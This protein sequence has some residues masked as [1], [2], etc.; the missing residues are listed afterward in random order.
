[1]VPLSYLNTRL[2]GFSL[3][4]SLC[5]GVQR[6]QRLSKA[7]KNCCPP[8]FRGTDNK[9]WDNPGRH[10]VI[11]IGGLGFEPL[12][13]GN[14]PSTTNHQAPNHQLEEPEGFQLGRTNIAAV[15]TNNH[16][17][18]V[19]AKGNSTYTL[20]QMEIGKLKKHKQQTD[21]LKQMEVGKL[22]KQR[23]SKHSFPTV[24]FEGNGRG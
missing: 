1:M 23:Q 7:T 16:L 22:K 21:T 2:N 11:W 15:W 12:V 5:R 24:A 8:M 9:A 10:Q 4:L 19:R 14:C 17:S 3:S 18:S 6:V 20:K 13:L